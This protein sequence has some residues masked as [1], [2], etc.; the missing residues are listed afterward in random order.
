MVLVFGWFLSAWYFYCNY[1]AEEVLFQSNPRIHVACRHFVH[2]GFTDHDFFAMQIPSIPNIFLAHP[3]RRSLLF[4]IFLP[5][6]ATHKHGLCRHAV[7]VC[8]PVR[9][10]RSCILS[11]RVNISSKFFTVGYAH[12]SIVFLHQTL[13]QYSNRKPLIGASNASGV[14]KY[15][16][17]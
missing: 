8:S 2:I 17:S 6:D 4:S 3:K 9:P 16:D 12:H 10:P 13:W 1:L 5:R 7:S 14:G 11:K 15:R